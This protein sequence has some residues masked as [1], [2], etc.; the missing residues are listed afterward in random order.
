MVGIGHTR[1]ATHGT[2]CEANAHPIATHRVAVVH[3]GII[4]N[5]DEL[6]QHLLSSGYRAQSETDTECIAGLLTLA[7]DDGRQPAEAL[8]STLPRLEGSF[9]LAVLVA[10]QPDMILCARRGSPLAIGHDDGVMYVGSDALALTPLTQSLSYLDDGDWAVITRRGAEVFDEAGRA[11]KR[12]IRRCEM[13]AWHVSKGRHRHYMAKEIGEQ[14]RVIANTLDML[15]DPAKC[16]RKL[17]PIADGLAAV[18]KVTIV[19]CGTSHFASA[20]ARYWFEQ[21]ANVPATAE[22]AS[23]FRYLRSPRVKNGLTLF[24]S[25]SGE[26]ADTLAC[27]R[28][29][30]RTGE[31]TLTLTN[32]AES[33]MARE[34][35]A[36]IVMPAGPEIGV[37]STK[38]FTAQ[39]A[40]LACLCVALGRAKGAITS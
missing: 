23:E 20:T 32:S 5:H 7:L 27:L 30:K 29:A 24:V 31:K 2:P 26:T 14:P 39:L 1:W 33:S 17:A 13:A 38:T 8:Q 40:A 12:S 25:Q 22:I 19:A 9:A 34:A 4:E 15:A 6:R 21:I 37:A 10:G 18:S 36:T 3:N 11:V 28:E 35:D 16:R